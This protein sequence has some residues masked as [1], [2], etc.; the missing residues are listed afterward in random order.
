MKLTLERLNLEYLSWTVEFG[1][2][3]DKQD[4]RFGQYL[5]NKYDIPSRLDVF[6]IEKTTKAYD[7]LLEGL[8]ELE[9]NLL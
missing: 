7:T 8:A 4:V 2:G 1:E 5:H 3:R 6:Y 9:Q